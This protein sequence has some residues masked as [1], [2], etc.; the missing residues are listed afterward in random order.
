MTGFGRLQVSAREGN[1]VLH[2]R[3]GDWKQGVLLRPLGP[4]HPD[5]LVVD[6]GIPDPSRLAVVRDGD[7]SVNRLIIGDGQIWHLQRT[8][9]VAPWA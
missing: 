7:G 5:V 1:L 2:S 9:R 8:D 3:R 4:E 6:E